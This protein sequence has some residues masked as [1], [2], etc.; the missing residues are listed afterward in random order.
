[1]DDSEIYNIP[2]VLF[3]GTGFIWNDAAVCGGIM[4]LKVVVRDSSELWILL[5]RESVMMFSFPLMFCDYRDVSFLVRLHPSHR[6]TMS[7]G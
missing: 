3:L 1:M 4:Y 5:E 6:A 7:W 2:E